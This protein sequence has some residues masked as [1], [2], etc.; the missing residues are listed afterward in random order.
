M[1]HTILY[2]SDMHIIES[3]FQEGLTFSEVKEFIS[4]G[5]RIAK[6]KDCALFLT[7]Y[8]KATLKLSTLEIY[9]VPK[10]MQETFASTGLNI[11]RIRRAVVAAKDLK[12]YLFYETVTI[13][14][15]QNAKV[16]YDIDEAKKWL[17]RK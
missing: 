10:L 9:E 5:V 16:F 6:E 7:D 8:R 17:L 2:N 11:R 14:R 3:T 1:S 12:D 13:N 4:E 15:G